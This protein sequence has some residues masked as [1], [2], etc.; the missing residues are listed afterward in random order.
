METLIQFPSAKII[1]KLQTVGNFSFNDELS[2]FLKGRQP[3]YVGVTETEEPGLYLRCPGSEN[4]NLY[5]DILGCSLEEIISYEWDD[6]IAAVNDSLKH[7]PLGYDLDVL[8]DLDFLEEEGLDEYNFPYFTRAIVN[9]NNDKM[10]ILEFEEYGFCIMYVLFF[11]GC[12]MS[13]FLIKRT[14]SVYNFFED[15]DQEN[16]EKYAKKFRHLSEK[17][18][19]KG[20]TVVESTEEF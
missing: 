10:M 15:M 16:Y 11:E 1:V 3:K 5:G 17:E 12:D 14:K 20:I 4:D 13:Q 19:S 18:L 7:F 9:P 8:S 2:D 6:S